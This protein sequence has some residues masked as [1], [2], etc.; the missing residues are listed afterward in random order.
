MPAGW[1]QTSGSFRD[2]PIEENTFWMLACI[3][4]K[5]GLQVNI[6]LE[7]HSLKK[8]ERIMF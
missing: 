6:K 8:K 7:V 2:G 3:M 4:E 5:Y 1:N